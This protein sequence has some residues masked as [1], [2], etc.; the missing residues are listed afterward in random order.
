MVDLVY[1]CVCAGKINYVVTVTDS[2]TDT[3][4]GSLLAGRPATHI[5]T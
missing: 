4:H 5:I 3:L 2:N 1:V